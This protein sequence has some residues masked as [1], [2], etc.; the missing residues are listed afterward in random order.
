[1]ETRLLSYT[2]TKDS[3]IAFFFWFGILRPSCPPSP[4]YKERNVHYTS[5]TLYSQR[6]LLF[7]TRL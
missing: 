2:T 4:H 3:E 6:D 1:M 5:A 7:F